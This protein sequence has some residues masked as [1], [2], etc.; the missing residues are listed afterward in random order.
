MTSSNSGNVQAMTGLC[1]GAPQTL[2][3]AG[4]VQLHN[5]SFEVADVSLRAGR[6]LYLAQSLMGLYPDNTD[7]R[8]TT[9]F[10]TNVAG[11]LDVVAAVV[12]YSYNRQAPADLH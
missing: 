6:R 1:S 7:S 5:V 3:P 9:Q 8:L 12:P 10:Q 2:A 11:L 4:I